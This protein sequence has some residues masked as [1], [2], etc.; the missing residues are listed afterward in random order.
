MVREAAKTVG[1]E[2]EQEPGRL[3]HGLGLSLDEVVD[4]VVA[5]EASD[6]WD[7]LGGHHVAQK[8]AHGVGGAGVGEPV[9][10]VD[11]KGVGGG[12]GVGVAVSGAVVWVEVEG[13]AAVEGEDSVEGMGCDG[14]DSALEE[15]AEGGV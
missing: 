15:G 4:C 7:A 6:E 11:D 2:H 1:A 13:N 3:A 12:D 14:G 8:P 10:E 9:E 5:H